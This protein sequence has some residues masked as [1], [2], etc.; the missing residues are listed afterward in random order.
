[1][2]A[3]SIQAV[4]ILIT[5]NDLRCRVFCKVAATCVG[6]LIVRIAGSHTRMGRHGLIQ[7]EQKEPKQRSQKKNHD[8]Q[9]DNL[10]NDQSYKDARGNYDIVC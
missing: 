8:F 9:R 2:C 4:I 10:S 6:T 5:V 7:C 1:V 3:V